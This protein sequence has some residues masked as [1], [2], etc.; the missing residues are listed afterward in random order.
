[1]VWGCVVDAPLQTNIHWEAFLHMPFIIY[2]TSK[3]FARLC[4]VSDF[5]LSAFVVRRACTQSSAVPLFLARSFA[6]RSFPQ[7]PSRRSQLTATTH[8]HHPPLRLTVDES[9]CQHS[10][11][12]HTE[13]IHRMA[14]EMARGARRLVEP[15]RAVRRPPA[16]LCPHACCLRCVQGMRRQ[17]DGGGA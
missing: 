15:L 8:C 10:D 16:H 6:S 12:A 14:E 2:L 13:M 1:M 9:T 11:Q 3:L 5:A 4:D 7:P 17:Q